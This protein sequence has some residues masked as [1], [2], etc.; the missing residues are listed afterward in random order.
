VLLGLV[1]LCLQFLDEPLI[2]GQAAQTSERGYDLHF[3]IT[4]GP[5]FVEEEVTKAYPLRSRVSS[6]SAL[7]DRVSSVKILKG[8]PLPTGSAENIRFLNCLAASSSLVALRLA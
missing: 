5:E 3:S 4:K 2:G 7:G 1:A 8:F 6:R